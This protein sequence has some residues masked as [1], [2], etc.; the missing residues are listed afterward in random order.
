MIFKFVHRLL[1]G[2]VHIRVFAGETPH[3]LGHA[4]NL[5]M[6]PSEWA[7]FKDAQIR[8]R[9]TDGPEPMWSEFEE[10]THD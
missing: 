1:G 5:I 10:D 4:G 2:H 7:A 8:A 6:R 3:S 9:T